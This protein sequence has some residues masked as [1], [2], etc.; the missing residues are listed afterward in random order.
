[1]VKNFIVK[2]LFIISHPR[3][4][5]NFIQCYILGKFSRKQLIRG[6]MEKSG[7]YS[8]I[9]VERCGVKKKVEEI[10]EKYNEIRLFYLLTDRVGE[11]VS[12]FIAIMD[13][14]ADYDRREILPVFVAG[15]CVNGNMRLV[16]IMSR[17]IAIVDE[18]NVSFWERVLKESSCRIN[19]SFW[20]QYMHR[21]EGKVISADWAGNLL[22]LN[23]EEE[24]EGKRKAAAMGVNSEFVCIS[25][26]D[27]A[28]LDSLNP[29]S[30]WSYHDYRDSDINN[31][32]LMSE[33]FEKKG[34]LCVRMG[35]VAKKKADF[36]NC[37]DY[38]NQ[39]YDELSDIYLS[40]HCKFF[41]GDNSG[42]LEMPTIV[43]TLIARTNVI[44]LFSGGYESLVNNPNDL[45]IPKLYR[46]KKDKRF[47]SFKEMMKIDMKVSFKTHEYEKL[48]I[49]VISNS[50]ED[51]L[52]LANEM[53]DR[54]NGTW[55]DT[56]EDQMLYQKYTK[57]FERYI[58]RSGKTR[59]SLIAARPGA[60][61]LRKHRFLL[62]A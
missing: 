13:D 20:H 56:D 58:E 45:Y 40:A 17:H 2:A 6:Y 48:N 4:I 37:I 35:R 5:R 39:Y 43:G 52:D 60:I 14:I 55:K 50:P 53:N 11:L 29:K 26:R 36:I 9:S 44:P 10:E 41:L 51:I 54:I 21:S 47:L 23:N 12:R 24:E 33:E 19:T 30:D 31:F 3:R 57:L 61:F 49:E 28:Y 27:S 7:E 16:R 32:Q 34:I 38:A 62:E 15:D 22:K 8:C 59:Q 42:I 18:T 46:S 25:N 1:M